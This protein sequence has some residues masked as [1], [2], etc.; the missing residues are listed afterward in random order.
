MDIR[1]SRLQSGNDAYGYIV[2]S[3]EEIVDLVNSKDGWTVYGWIKIVLIN[4]VSLLVN[5]IKDPGENKVLSQEISTHVV[6]LFPSK[7]YYLN[8]STIWARSL[9]N[10]KFDFYTL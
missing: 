2:D 4:D 1:A 8:L 10:L 5:D 6:H 7:K 9:D 3:L